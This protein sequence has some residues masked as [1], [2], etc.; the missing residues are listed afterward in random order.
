VKTKVL[1]YLAHGRRVAGTAV[2]F[3]G[4]DGA[5]GLFEASMEDLPGV[6]AALSADIE[7]EDVARRRDLAQRSWM[8]C[9]HG[10]G[11]I[12]E[13]WREALEN[14]DKVATGSAGTRRATRPTTP[15]ARSST[16]PPS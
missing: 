4:L 12:A 5:P 15:G 7:Q 10:R 2:A 9:H 8:E 11:H 3:E 1:H 6:I 16:T 14:L 13:Q